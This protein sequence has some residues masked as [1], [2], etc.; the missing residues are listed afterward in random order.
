[1]E[2]QR[3]QEAQAEQVSKR[4]CYFLF[5][6]LAESLVFSGIP[7]RGL[8]PLTYCL[9]GSCSV[10]LSY[11]GAEYPQHCRLLLSSRS[12]KIIYKMMPR[13]HRRTI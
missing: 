3:A 10:L 12:L 9:E 6:P 13:V 5:V 2:G 11:G 1:M 8:E 4:F 7:P